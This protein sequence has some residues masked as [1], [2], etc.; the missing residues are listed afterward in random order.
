[1]VKLDII[2]PAKNEADNLP[3]LLDRI[4]SVCIASDIDYK[5]I[6]IDDHST[7]NSLK[8]LETLKQK[9]PLEILIKKGKPGKAFS[10]LE[11]IEIAETEYVLM[12]DA[13][14][15]Y[16]PEAIPEMLK[17]IPEHGVVIAERSKQKTTFIRQLL[18]KA[19]RYL[20]GKFTLGIDCDAQSGLKLFRK[21]IITHLDPKEVD[22]WAIDMPLLHTALELGLTIGCV[23]I[24]F[25]ERQNGSSKVNLFN[26]SKEIL[27][28]ALKLKF[29]TRKVYALPPE[30]PETMIG[31]GVI[32]KRR[33]FITHTHLH[34]EH[35]AIITLE[36]WQKL[37]LIALLGSLFL[38]FE[39]DA[40]DTAI[41]FVAVLSTIY[42]LDVFFNLFLILKSLHFPPEIYFNSKELEQINPEKLPRYTILCPLYRE[43]RV[44]SSFVDSINNLDYPKEK[45]DVLLLLE[46]DDTATIEAAKELNLPKHFR[47]IIVPDSQPKTKPK[48]C[49]YGLSMAKGEYV[50]IYDAED[51][52]DPDQLKKA[53]LGFQNSPDNI[54]CLQAKLN[55]YNPRT[56][57]L[58]RLFTAEYSLWFDITLPGLQ[59][60]S[61]TIP[62]GGTSNHF[63]TNIL[64]E[65]RGWD[66]FNV[67]EDCD[68]GARLF[69]LGYQTAIIDSTTLEE[70]NSHLG[71]W[72]RQRSRWI[73]GY[74]QTY[75]VHN[76]HPLK[77]IRSHGIHAFIFQ[78]VVGG[79]IAFMVIN[80]I[81]WLMTLSYFLLYSIVGPTI[82]TLYP[83]TI[84]Y[85]AV[86][87]MI[88]GNFLF[89]YYYMIGCAKRGH[90]ELIKYV[91]F[92][93]FYWI[94]IS[95][96]AGKALYQLIVKPHFWE[97]TNH[98][99]HLKP[100]I[101]TAKI[102]SE[103]LKKIKNI[104]KSK[105]F[106]GGSLV[107]ATGIANFFNFLY[108]VYLGRTL[109]IEEF[110]IIS[111]IGSFIYFSYLIIGALSKTITYR[112]A[113]FFGK[114]QT[115]IKDHWQYFRFK[116]FNYSII[117]TGIWLML[118]PFLSKFFNINT[119]I[120][121]VLFTPIWIIY[122]V[123]AIDGGFLAGNHRFVIISII[124]ISETII[125]LLLS[126]IF[127]NFGLNKFIYAILP[128]S[129]FIPF[130]FGWLAAKNLKQENINID[131]KIIETFPQKFFTT[132]ILVQ[133]SVITFLSLDVLL[134]KHFLSATEA[135]QYAL[136][137]LTGKMVFFAGGLFSQFITPLIGREQ[138]N[139][140]DSNLTFYRL[141]A[142][143]IF[144]SLLGFITVGVFG[145]L[146]VPIL[147]GPKTN[148][149]LN[150]LPTYTLAMVCFTTSIAIVNYHQTLRHYTFPVIS[151][152]FAGFQLIGLYF[153]HDNLQTVVRVMQ[154][155]GPIYLISILISH[156]FYKQLKILLN[157]IF[158]FLLLFVHLK[159]PKKIDSNKISIL[160]FNWRDTK[161]VW[162]GGAEVY[163]HELA[164]RWVIMGH[165]VTLFCGNDGKCVRND[166]ID[167]V[168]IIRRGGF[169]T[170]YI[171][172]CIYYLL[173]F[174][175]K[176]DIIIDSEN[177]IPFFTP[178]YSWLPKFLLIHH[179]HQN[180]FRDHLPYPLAQ[181]AMF[182][183]SKVMPLLYRGQKIVTVSNSSRDDIIRLNIGKNKDISI[184]NPG[185]ETDKFSLSEK[186]PHPSFIYLG[187]IRPYKNIDTAIKAFSLVN[188]KYPKARLS[189]AGWGENINELKELTSKLKLE[190]SVKFLERISEQ[191]KI[192]LLGQS[193]VMLQPSS[194]EGWGITVIEANA[195]G[196]PVIA[197]NTIGLR[198]SV[199]NNQTG[200]LFPARDYQKMA[201]LME[202]LID[203]KKLLKKLS[204]KAH[205]WSKKFE[206]DYQANT[207]IDILLNRVNSHN[208]SVNPK[209]LLP[210]YVKEKS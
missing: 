71:N 98:G 91:F 16:P 18:S 37:F 102:E 49:N 188:K 64:K 124:I 101:A 146:T 60:I 186:T 138:G 59:S 128:I 100:E 12:I 142:A 30:S 193:W 204:E 129:A 208:L 117:A 176:Y 17:L 85:M 99:L 148:P 4:S 42:F 155:L 159:F 140:K 130:I 107:F 202:Y 67:T 74:I 172:A 23:N 158:D 94:A 170:V 141:L 87:S 144:A 36:S 136:L 207:F 62:L 109:S 41:V 46:E 104:S 35:S 134:V 32:H 179:V 192:K 108:N 194:F 96:A 200:L 199:S 191:E 26:T 93:P 156:I 125:K 77:F 201:D 181:I 55:Y 95:I 105:Y 175:G 28:R 167:G 81:L 73:K 20:L 195:C 40:L 121:F 150:L 53:F 177:G 22:A 106:N 76:R 139:K 185:I 114:Y 132:S 92:I 54:V 190:N 133:V 169:F 103:H 209:T 63:R 78:L 164:K 38:G 112:S 11:G 205:Q 173:K 131:R 196:T 72:I 75:L 83:A 13:D 210:A 162:A 69:K 10:I 3:A 189:I 45:L 149:I 34:H 180:V 174:R 116:T 14:L 25:A 161:H 51:R 47:T 52:P 143:T 111:L 157:N 145:H 66:P 39:F 15:Q 50:V 187:R 43:A 97:K 31:A 82:E 79:K 21:G 126:I 206:W 152:F 1:M 166:D 198:D 19:N 110:G 68:L 160:I 48:A 8:V 65:L 27:F 182:L 86:F 118:T 56:N 84:F 119:I 88:F 29:K 33:Q 58:T 127:I 9:Y 183:E 151:L 122:T 165:Q 2:I 7:D 120:P 163:V 153:F 115:V 24:E 123:G 113:Y 137:A 203:D 57:L 197:S 44:L 171:W 70:A 90:Y 168:K 135:G 6:I 178:I 5:A 80:P 154:V 61:T 147:F 89:L 184:I